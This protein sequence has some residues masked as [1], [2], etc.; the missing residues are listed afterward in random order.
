MHSGGGLLFGPPQCIYH[1]YALGHGSLKTVRSK[2]HYV[3][4]EQQRLLAAN[5]YFIKDESVVLSYCTHT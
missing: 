3:Q 1:G 4:N 5:D 2:W